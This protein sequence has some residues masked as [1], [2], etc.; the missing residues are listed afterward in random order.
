MRKVIEW[1]PIIGIIYIG[2]I[3]KINAGIFKSTFLSIL[4]GVWHGLTILLGLLLILYFI[5]L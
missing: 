1:I 5:I 3:V 2:F 4:N